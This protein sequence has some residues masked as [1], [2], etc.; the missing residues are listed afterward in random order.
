MMQKTRVV[1]V[2]ERPT[3]LD[4]VTEASILDTF[5]EAGDIDWKVSVESIENDT[6]RDDEP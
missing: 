2:I 5:S 6:P 4:N 3:D 1:L